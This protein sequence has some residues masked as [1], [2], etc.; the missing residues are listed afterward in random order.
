MIF[1]K[2]FIPRN[3]Y[4]NTQHVQKGTMVCIARFMSQKNIILTTPQNIEIFDSREISKSIL[5]DPYNRI[6]WS[7]YQKSNNS[8]YTDLRTS[9]KYK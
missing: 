5:V 3:I 6:I 4:R 8:M 7:S 1:P 9:S 2:N